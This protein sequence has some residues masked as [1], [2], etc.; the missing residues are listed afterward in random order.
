MARKSRSRGPAARTDDVA[1]RLHSAAIHLLRRL[2][3]RDVEAGVSAAR[4][5]VLSLLVHGGPRPIGQLALVEQVSAPTMSR[6]VRG[7]E[8][9][10][11]IG[12]RPDP[13][14]ARV[15]HVHVKARGRRLLERAKAR[16]VGELA[17]WM[18][19]LPATEVATLGAAA[20][21]IETVVRQRPRRRRLMS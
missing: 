5:S 8:E 7:L 17:T 15:V 12:R 6:L 2:R 14:D 13:D 3:R 16:R 10:G 4:L 1:D 18:R 9:D 21:L 20:D 11:L 19:D